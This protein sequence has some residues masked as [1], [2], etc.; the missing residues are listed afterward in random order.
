MRLKSRDTITPNQM[1]SLQLAS[2]LSGTFKAFTQLRDSPFLR[3]RDTSSIIDTK[4]PY[5]E[6]ITSL[7]KILRE[8]EA[9]CPYASVAHFFVQ[10]KRLDQPSKPSFIQMLSLSGFCPSRD[11]LTDMA[12]IALNS[13]NG[14]LLP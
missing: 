7:Q 8:T 14:L 6:L 9:L 1:L 2:L 5:I 11:D 4:T 3:F 13:R 10:V 12:Q